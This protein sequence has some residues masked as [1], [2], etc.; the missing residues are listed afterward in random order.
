MVKNVPSVAKNINLKIQKW[1]YEL[2]KNGISSIDHCTGNRNKKIPYKII[3]TGVG[4]VAQQ[5]KPSL[6]IPMSHVGMPRVVSSKCTWEIP[7]NS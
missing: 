1:E 6:G 4:I 5:I 7:I 3:K 2:R